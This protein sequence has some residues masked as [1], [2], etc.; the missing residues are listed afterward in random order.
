MTSPDVSLIVERLS[1]S[2]TRRGLGLTDEIALGGR[3][4]T[5]REFVDVLAL[6]LALERRADV[7]RREARSERVRTAA[8][9][10]RRHL[11]RRARLFA[12]LAGVIPSSMTEASVSYDHRD[13]VVSEF[14][15]LDDA[16]GKL[17]AATRS[18][19]DLTGRHR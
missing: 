4:T 1:Q 2:L 16:E 17:E 12:S 15:I 6:I 13:P 18:A 3:R 5:R 7:R 11:R 14:V 19:L 10:I 8:E 9:R